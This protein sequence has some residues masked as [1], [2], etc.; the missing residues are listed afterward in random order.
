VGGA[1][2]YIE[3]GRSDALRSID[4]KVKLDGNYGVDY[5][6]DLHLSNTTDTAKNIGI[7]FAPEAGPAAGVF[8][9]DNGEYLEYN[10]TKVEDQPLLA[11]LPLA[12][13]EHRDVHIRTIPLNGGFYPAAVIV[14]QL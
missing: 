14:H 4:G 6:I 8:Q 10:P 7:F 5:D 13:G 1:W 11:K 9:I 12:P 2:Q 3:M